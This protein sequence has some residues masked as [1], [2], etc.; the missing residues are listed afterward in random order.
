MDDLTLC[1]TSD[2]FSS[3]LSTEAPTTGSW[4]VAVCVLSLI[5]W[6]VSDSLWKPRSTTLLL[7]PALKQSNYYD[8]HSPL[9]VC[10]WGSWSW[11]YSDLCCCNV[12]YQFETRRVLTEASLERVDVDEMK[13]WF[14]VWKFVNFFFAYLG[15]KNQDIFLNL[16]IGQISVLDK[17][18]EA[19][20]PLFTHKRDSHTQWG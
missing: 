14:T 10:L 3:L 19:R 8:F 11:R 5:V 13:A 6:D 15:F 12:W 17:E 2:L 1:V 18:S 9:S 4:V 16:V 20:H 7:A